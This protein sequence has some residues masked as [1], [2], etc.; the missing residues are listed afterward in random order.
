MEAV[1]L[2]RPA[3]R[4]RAAARFDIA[5]VAK[6]YAELYAQMAAPPRVELDMAAVG[7]RE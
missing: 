3:I 7:A 4:A 1:K 5:V 6:Q 2:D